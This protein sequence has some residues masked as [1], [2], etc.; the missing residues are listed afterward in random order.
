[1]KLLIIIAIS[2]FCIGVFIITST[3]AEK[4]QIVSSSAM[5]L[6]NIM[7][8]IHINPSEY[9]PKEQYDKDMRGFRDTI[10]QL[11]QMIDARELTPCYY[12]DDS[13]IAQINKSIE[14]ILQNTT[15]YVINTSSFTRPPS[16]KS[17]LE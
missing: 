11:R 1:M 15:F 16:L 6:T 12:E 3:L 5:H 14:Q 4:S 10:S 13:Y 17:T 9:V 7:P 2:I 8:F